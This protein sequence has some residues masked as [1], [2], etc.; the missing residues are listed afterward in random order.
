MMNITKKSLLMLSLRGATLASKFILITYLAKYSSF[1]VLAGYSLIS[2]TVSYFLYILGFDFYSYSSREIISNTYYKSS[3]MIFNQFFFYIVM[4]VLSIPLLIVFFQYNIISSDLL[5]LFSFVL[6]SEHLSQEFMRLIVINGHALKANFQLFLRTASWIYLYIA[7]SYNDSCVSL[8]NLL[9]FWA[10][11]N[12]VAIAYSLTELKY[13]KWRGTSFWRINIPWI[14]QGVKIAIPLLLATLMLRAIFVSDRYFLKFMSSTQDLAIYSFFSN[15]ANALIAFVDAAV[16]MIFY[17]KLVNA[18]NSKDNEKYNSILAQFKVS[19]FKIGGGV[20]ILLSA[21]MPVM[22]YFLDKKDFM[23]SIVIFYILISSTFIYSFGLIYHYELYARKKDRIILY[24]TLVSFV[25]GVGMQY[26]LGYF[27]Q[28]T[29]VACGVLFSTLL[30]FF[31]KA[32]FVKYVK[33]VL[34]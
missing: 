32:Y 26:I 24:S 25:F 31:M 18:F 1:E 3:G 29:G 34:L 9:I 13:T 7:Y 23:N 22:C 4:Y 6:I 2:I 5:F 33:R 15:M 27:F 21:F 28:S 10:S 11:A 17:P 14:W 8:N 12:V 20:L 30:L 19:V 16:I